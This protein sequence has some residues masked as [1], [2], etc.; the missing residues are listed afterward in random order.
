MKRRG[1]LRRVRYNATKLERLE[2][3]RKPT[4]VKVSQPPNDSGKRTRFLS[5]VG[6][7]P[8]EGNPLFLAS[9]R[10]VDSCIRAVAM[11]VN[12]LNLLGTLTAGIW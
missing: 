9:T 11:E 7:Q 6:D 1:L 12:D 10:E 8:H 5:F 4:E 2:R 3:K